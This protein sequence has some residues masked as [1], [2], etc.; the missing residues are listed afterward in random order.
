MKRKAKRIWSLKT[1]DHVD[2][3]KTG[4]GREWEGEWILTL[5]YNAYIHDW[6]NGPRIDRHETGVGI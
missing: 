4:Y 1:F 5:H 3:G 2:S 6:I